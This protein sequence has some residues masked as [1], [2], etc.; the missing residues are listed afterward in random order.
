MRFEFADHVLDTDRRELT[1]G[2][3]LIAISP[4][5]FDLLAFLI[6]HR[7]RVVS[8]DDLVESVWGGRIISD[9]TVTSHIN[10]VRKALGD[11][12]EERRL[13]RTLARK[14]FRFVGE[15][16]TKQ[17]TAPPVTSTDAVSPV[18][19]SSVPTPPPD[20]PSIAVMPFENLS[21]DSGQE[22]FSDGLA[23]DI[24]TALSKIERMRVIARNSTFAYKGQAHNL[25][26]IDEELGIQYVLEGSVRRG[27]NRLRITAQL[28]DTN[29]GSHLWAERYDRAVFDLFDIQDEITK[30]IV[31]SLRV[32]LTD[33][34]QAR[35]WARGTNYIDAW[36]YGIQA[37][38]I[39][40]RFSVSDYLEARTFAEKA[41]ELDPNYAHA[42]AALGFTYWFE[43]RLGYLGDADAKFEQAAGYAER[44]MALDESVSSAIGLAALVAAPLGRS[45]DGVAV[46]RR[47]CEVNPGNADVR[48]FLGYAL[49]SAGNYAEGEEH[50]R[51]AIS[52]NPFP[53][54]FYRGSLARALI[55]Q[56]SLD[57]ALTLVDE[58]LDAEPTNL[59]G[60]VNRAAI[61]GQSG[62]QAEAQESVR[63]IRRLAPK[64]CASHL[65]GILLVADPV[66]FRRYRDAVHGAGLPE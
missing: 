27:G 46:A 53:P 56:E 26:R 58:V 60:W 7:E 18:T 39:L 52:L 34:E 65:R 23:E 2:F 24:I 43:G 13:I 63:E 47:G 54:N 48:F 62:H 50:I 32:K 12:G 20:K 19:H 21:S 11:T 6:E 5:A 49:T 16:T 42:W 15:V 33:G 8:K 45:E 25:R 35:V 36:Q 38:E 28:V 37:W 41:E 59:L 61:C 44:A 9:S 64:L 14:G 3:E 17:K 30:E 51:D 40:R 66:V 1:R 29:D 55:C 22:F 10:A 57:E 31:T 4:K